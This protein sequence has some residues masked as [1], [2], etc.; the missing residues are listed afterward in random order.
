M[1]AGRDDVALYRVTYGDLAA[2][3][4]YVVEYVCEDLDASAG[5]EDIAGD[6][7]VDTDVPAGGHH[8]AVDLGARVHTFAREVEVL[9]DHT[10][11]DDVLS[12]FVTKFVMGRFGPGGQGTEREKRKRGGDQAGAYHPSVSLQ[13]G[14]APKDTA[15]EYS[16]PPCRSGGVAV[17]V[18]RVQVCDTARKP[19][20]GIRLAHKYRTTR[21]TKLTE[22][23]PKVV[24]IASQMSGVPHGNSAS[25]TYSLSRPMTIAVR[26]A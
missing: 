4:A 11:T 3:G 5:R 8:I 1:T 9:I 22:S 25:N 14:R 21:T 23:P 17:F 10:F 13:D 2:C 24:A 6:P 15:G 19:V 18:D 26:S 16:P 12:K 7:I 20:A